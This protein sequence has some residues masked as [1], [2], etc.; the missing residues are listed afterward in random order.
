MIRESKNSRQGK[1]R[2]VDTM[3]QWLRDG[4]SAGSWSFPEG[5]FGDHVRHALSDPAFGKVKDTDSLAV[6]L[7]RNRSTYAGSFAAFASLCVEYVEAQ[8]PA[9][10]AWRRKRETDRI[11]KVAAASTARSQR[12]QS[13]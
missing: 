6:Y 2:T 12:A 1:L 4:L 5:R 3:A 13:A 9:Y 10:L 11:E 8:Q 7:M